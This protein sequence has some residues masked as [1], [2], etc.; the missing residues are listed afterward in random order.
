MNAS[1]RRVRREARK[2]RGKEVKVLARAFWPDG[3]RA[4]K[5]ARQWVVRRYEDLI[6]PRLK[7]PEEVLE[8]MR[9]EAAGR[10][11]KALKV[12]AI[13]FTKDMIVGVSGGVRPTGGY[14]VEVTKVEADAAGK[15]LTV[16][17]RLSAPVGARRR[18]RS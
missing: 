9:R 2:A 3:W 8:R 17:W 1:R 15:R 13:D 10:Y 7:A 18:R 4:E 6:D 11:A 5:P 12:D 14:H 16:H